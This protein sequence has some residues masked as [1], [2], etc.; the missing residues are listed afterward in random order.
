M[1]D[2]YIQNG[3][4]YHARGNTIIIEIEEVKNTGSSSIIILPDDRREELYLARRTG[5]VRAIGNFAWSDKGESY[6]KVGDK[7][8]FKRYAGTDLNRTLEGALPKDEPLLRTMED[9]EIQCVIEDVES[10]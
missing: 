4:K 10:K 2:N 1:T 3:K 7:V 5:F 6:A 9:F 8:I